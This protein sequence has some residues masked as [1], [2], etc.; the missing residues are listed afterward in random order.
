KEKEESPDPDFGEKQL[1]T[2]EEQETV[3]LNDI[4]DQS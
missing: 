4:N 2:A 1:A 3:D